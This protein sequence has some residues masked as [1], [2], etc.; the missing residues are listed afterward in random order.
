MNV[1]VGNLAEME[2]VH[3]L[4]LCEFPKSTTERR[5]VHKLTTHAVPGSTPALGLLLALLATYLSPIHVRYI[6]A[7]QF[8]EIDE[9]YSKWPRE[10]LPVKPGF[11]PVKTTTYVHTQA[12]EPQVAAKSAAVAP[13]PPAVRHDSASERED[14]RADS[15]KAPTPILEATLVTTTLAAATR[16]QGDVSGGGQLGPEYDHLETENVRE[17]LF[18]EEGPCA[19]DAFERSLETIGRVLDL[20]TAPGGG[21]IFSIPALLPP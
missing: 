20:V 5:S 3:A 1:K 12:A 13:F 14:R 9:F 10:A 7:P 15:G 4:G 18:G 17:E 2:T 21:L 8:P 6:V 11:M 16:G 19:E